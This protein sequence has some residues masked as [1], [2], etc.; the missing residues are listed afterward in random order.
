[1]KNILL[2]FILLSIES[3]SQSEN[4]GEGTY[5][6]QDK[7]MRTTDGVKAVLEGY[8]DASLFDD[9]AINYCN[10]AIN[11]AVIQMKNYLMALY[12]NIVS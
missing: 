5:T 3:T 7:I 8:P 9:A 2:L 4:S 10:N 11:D 1:M 12:I 6:T